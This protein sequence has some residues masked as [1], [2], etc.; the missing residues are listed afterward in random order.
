MGWGNRSAVT[1]RELLRGELLQGRV[2]IRSRL[3][4]RRGRVEVE[5]FERI[6]VEDAKVVVNTVRDHYKL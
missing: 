5:L 3:L 6:E 4:E 2:D 1:H